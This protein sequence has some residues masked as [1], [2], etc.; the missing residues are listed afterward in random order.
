[1]GPPLFVVFFTENPLKNGGFFIE[2]NEIIWY[3]IPITILKGTV[4]FLWSI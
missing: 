3:H 4:I 2:M 1:M